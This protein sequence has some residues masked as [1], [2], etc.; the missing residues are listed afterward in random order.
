MARQLVT[1]Q[2]DRG[3]GSGWHPAAL[4]HRIQWTSR[5]TT[6]ANTGT[7]TVTAAGILEDGTPWIARDQTRLT[8]TGLSL[9]PP[10][11]ASNPTGHQHPVGLDRASDRQH[12]P[13]D[14]KD[15]T[16]TH[17]NNAPDPANAD[18]PASVARSTGAGLELVDFIR[19][20]I[21]S[22]RALHV[23]SDMLK[24]PQD[25][26]DFNVALGMARALRI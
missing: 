14:T 16:A 13:M 4:V 1:A 20:F 22:I 7:G 18:S 15:G 5:I 25:D 9:R 21:L 24:F 10:A 12:F 17:R 6:S 26:P 11:Y 2:G 3:T 8:N 23:M 19:H